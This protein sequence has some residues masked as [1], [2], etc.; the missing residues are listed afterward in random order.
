MKKDYDNPKIEIIEFNMKDIIT[1]SFTGSSDNSEDG[2][3]DL[4]GLDY[5]D[6]PISK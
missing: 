5:G 2:W 6:F 1:E 3:T 4:Y